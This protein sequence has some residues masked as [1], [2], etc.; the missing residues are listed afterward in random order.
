M[1]PQEGP[2]RGRQVFQEKS[3]AMPCDTSMLATHSTISEDYVIVR[4]TTKGH[5]IA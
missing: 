4:V 3:F 1:L 2:V 5:H